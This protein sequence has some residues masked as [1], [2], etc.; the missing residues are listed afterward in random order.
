MTFKR[1]TLIG[2]HSSTVSWTTSISLGLRLSSPTDS[3][4]RKT[5]S[6]SDKWPYASWN[7][8]SAPDVFMRSSVRAIIEV[9]AMKS[10][11]E[12]PNDM[13]LSRFWFGTWEEFRSLGGFRESRLRGWGWV[14]AQLCSLWHGSRN[15]IAKQQRHAFGSFNV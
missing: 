4:F 11:T 1:R 3:I 12:N 15:P 2:W 13:M 6:S 10:P 5:S 9:A 7:S 14:R 8:F